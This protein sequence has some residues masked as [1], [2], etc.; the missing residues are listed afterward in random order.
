[1]KEINDYNAPIEIQ[2]DILTAIGGEGEKHYNSPFDVQYA[3]L[4]QIEGGGEG[5]LVHEAPIDGKV[6]G[7]KDADWAEISANFEAVVADELPTAS[8]DTMGKMYL[9]PSAD[10]QEQ[11]VRDEYITINTDNVY[12]WEQ[13]GSTAID[14]SDYYTKDEVDEIIETEEEVIS[15]ALNKLNDEKQPLLTAGTNITIDEDN[16]ISATGGGN[17]IV[18]LT[19]AE[20]NAL[21]PEEK[22]NGS[23]YSITDATI[24]D[25]TNYYT[26]SESNAAFN[27]YATVTAST[28]GYKFPR[29]NARGQIDGTTATAY[30]ASQ[31]INGSS[32]SIYSTS[33]SSLPT[34][35]APTAAGT[36]GQVL[37]SNGSGAP[38]W[39]DFKSDATYYLSD[40]DAAAGTYSTS[41]AEFYTECIENNKIGP[42]QI[43]FDTDHNETIYSIGD[44]AT[45]FAIND[46]IGLECTEGNITL[47][48]ADKT[49]IV[50]GTTGEIDSTSTISATLIKCDG[51]FIIIQLGEAATFNESSIYTVT[52]EVNTFVSHSSY[53]P[54]STRLY[55]GTVEIW[56]MTTE[57]GAEW[58]L[59]H[60]TITN[61]TI[62]KIT[63]TGT[64]GQN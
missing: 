33:S 57:D 12:S 18:E 35:Y 61:S 36:T 50:N 7:R 17:S 59:D 4:E 56:L 40:T 34:I 46:L 11:N 39:Q 29:W 28:S 43:N 49:L 26:K 3:I 20:Y 1:M 62:S 47:T 53:L 45:E 51:S 6:Y 19:Q 24:Y 25:M 10:P 13:I 22:E 16:V 64:F 2:K 48:T 63:S 30:Q 23:I 41:I 37:V 32:R 38:T 14:L 44:E 8:A 9:I 54:S 42:L 60:Y 15:T 58:E 27:P 5:G 21:T 52:S 55:E 31:S